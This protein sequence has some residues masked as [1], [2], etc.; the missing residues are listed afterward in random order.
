MSI[1]VEFFGDGTLVEQI[2]G[3][4]PPAFRYAPRGGTWIRSGSGFQVT[5][6]RLAADDTRLEYTSS[7]HVDPDGSIE[8]P[9]EGW[10]T[11]PELRTRKSVRLVRQE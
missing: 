1:A 9:M 8:W 7:V 5:R 6:V 4:K 11:H 10:S 2:S 3:T